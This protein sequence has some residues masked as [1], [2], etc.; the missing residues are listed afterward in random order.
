VVR[1]VGYKS[2]LGVR[3][4]AHRCRYSIE[5]AEDAAE[6][7]TCSF[8]GCS[9]SFPSKQG[10]TNHARCHRKHV[11]LE[12]AAVPLP[13]LATRQR[14]RANPTLRP[15]RGGDARVP[16]EEM[17]EV[18]EDMPRVTDRRTQAACPLLPSQRRPN[19]GYRL[20]SDRRTQAVRSHAR[21]LDQ[22]YRKVPDH[23]TQAV[24]PR[25]HRGPACNPP[26]PGGP[27]R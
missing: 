22:G 14:T 26:H 18:M 20:V 5:E 16:S 1:C 4:G 17:V 25:Y 7:F 23:R 8:E 21:E 15:V 13:A 6:R 11:A 19:Q 12:A 27:H 24:Q 3:P 9:D 10:L 2:V